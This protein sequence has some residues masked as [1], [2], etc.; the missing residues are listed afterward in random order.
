MTFYKDWRLIDGKPRLVIV[1]ENKNIIDRSPSKDELKLLVVYPKENYNRKR[2]KDYTD[3]E[4]LNCLIHFYEEYGRPP[5]EK[6]FTSNHKYPNF[7]TYVSRF[8]SWTNALKRIGLDVESMVK[9]GLLVTSQ[10]KGRFTEIIIRDHFKKNPVDLAGEN[11]KSP[12]DG[13]C[14]NG[15]KYDVKSSGLHIADNG[16]LYWKFDTNNKYK[17]KIEIYYFIAFNEDYSELMYVWRVSAWEVIEKEHF[18]VGANNWSRR[19]F[20]VE[21]MKEYDI[22]EKFKDVL[23]KYR[24]FDKEIDDNTL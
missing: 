24:F 22:T 15:L 23:R 20:T 4:L 13:I 1:D 6:D 3:E 17:D 21:N 16:W 19:E 5:T 9:R 7:M 2:R 8:G 12:C 11:C 10:Q 14:P 18:Y